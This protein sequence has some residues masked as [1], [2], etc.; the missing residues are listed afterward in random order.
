MGARGS[1][2]GALALAAAAL[3]AAASPVA[4]E[5]GDGRLG[6]PP[7]PST[8]VFDSAACPAGT[9][10]TGVSGTTRLISVSTVVASI[11]PQCVGPG[12]S[13]TGSTMG[14]ADATDLPA[15]TSCAPGQ[16]AVGVQGFEGDFIDLLLLRCQ[17]ANLTGPVTT[18][19]PNF[20]G[21]GGGADGP[22]DCPAGEALVGFTGEVVPVGPA[23]VRYVEISCTASAPPPVVTPPSTTTPVT[24]TSGAVPPPV[25]GR[26]MNVQELKGE[27]LIA[28]PAGATGSGRARV[29]QKGLR[30]VPL[31]QVRQIPVGSFLDT[32]RGTVRLTTARDAAGRTQSGDFSAGL[33][34]VLQSRA[35]S[36]RGLTD[37]VLKGSSFRSCRRAR[38]GVAETAARRRRTI[39][40]L[41]SNA[42][43]RFRTRGR[44]SA[45]TVRGTKWTVTDRCD[46]TLTKVTRG[47]VVVR[48]FRRR[49]SVTVRAGKRTRGGGR[50]SYLARAR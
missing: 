10:I 30:F 48:D 45:A 41:R 7:E 20:G 31:E 29:S 19:V 5:V 37:V 8:P 28:I 13:A 50:G 6:G 46:G 16:V 35:R 43:G 17:A 12:G 15:S 1:G 22:Y 26:R 24:N 2:L 27:V 11:T 36:A 47:S 18:S 25:L 4:A 49:R 9:V 34:Q 14:N 40:R 21:G 39:R 23:M 42:R 32:R 33:F 38:S 3:G 44:Y